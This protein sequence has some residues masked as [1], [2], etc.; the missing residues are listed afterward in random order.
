MM[1]V[2]TTFILYAT[3]SLLSYEFQTT[4]ITLTLGYLLF[5]IGLY[6]FSKL[7]DKIALEK[8]RLFCPP[9][10]NS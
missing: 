5:G 6:N 10:R 7:N 9:I 4:I 8:K 1:I 3:Y 2:G